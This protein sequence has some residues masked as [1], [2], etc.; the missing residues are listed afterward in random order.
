MVIN[1]TTAVSDTHCWTVEVGD[2]TPGGRG[3]VLGRGPG[4]GAWASVLPPAPLRA[5]GPHVSHGSSQLLW[6]NV[7]RREGRALCVQ[8]SQWAVGIGVRASLSWAPLSAVEISA[9]TYC[10][11]TTVK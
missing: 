9:K 1:G 4:A 2:R 5:A 6:W 7:G 10:I 8:A 11:L 3:A